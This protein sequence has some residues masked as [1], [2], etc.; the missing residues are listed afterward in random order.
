ML[1]ADLIAPIPSLR[2]F[3]VS[4]GIWALIAFG[5]EIAKQFLRVEPLIDVQVKAQLD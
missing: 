3:W 5:V 2:C 1:K 4:E